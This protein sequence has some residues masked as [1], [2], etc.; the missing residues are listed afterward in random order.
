MKFGTCSA[1]EQHF[2]SI[3]LEY[4]GYLPPEPLS[5]GSPSCYNFHDPVLSDIYKGEDESLIYQ[6]NLLLRQVGHRENG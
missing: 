1:G 5:A 2:L 6:G 3:L 4:E